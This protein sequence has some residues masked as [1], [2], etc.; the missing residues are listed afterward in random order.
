MGGSPP[1]L[2]AAALTPPAAERLGDRIRRRFLS[3]RQPEVGP[4]QLH[5][6][7]IY[8]LPTRAGLLFIGMLGVMTM[9]SMNYGLNLGFLLTALLGGAMWAAMLQTWRNLAGLML[10][11]GQSQS[12]TPVHEGQDLVLHLAVHNPQTRAR[13]ALMLRPVSQNTLQ[14]LG[15]EFS[16]AAL[17]RD[18]LGVAW[19]APGIGKHPMPV[20]C[21]ETRFPL[22]LWRAWSYWRPA[23]QVWVYPAAESGQVPPPSGQ[24]G[25]GDGPDDDEDLAG[26]RVARPT[27]PPSRMA[28]KAM[29]RGH[30]QLVAKAFDRRGKL[31][32]R[33]LDWQTLAQLPTEQRIARLVRWVL[34]AQHDGVRYALKLPTQQVSADTGVKHQ[35]QCLRAITELALA[36]RTRQQRNTGQE[37]R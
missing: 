18:V 29:A 1:S 4:T 23:D 36:Q 32:D 22:G 28:W 16:L 37:A 24:S 8:I 34:D 17:A 30:Q 35:H 11:V 31:G 2:A 33:V 10:H 5:H 9:A 14:H 19:S 3:P 21:I 27:D 7:R 25:R 13:T 26:L 20:L 6:R 15:T 12:S